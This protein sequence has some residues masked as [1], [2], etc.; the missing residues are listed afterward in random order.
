MKRK[1]PQA[2]FTLLELMVVVAII[3]ILAAVAFPAY[4]D[5][6][7]RGNR[8]DA[9]GRL[10]QLATML[11]R[12]KSQQLSYRG[13]TL[14]MINGGSAALPSTGEAKY[15]LTL[16]LTPA[17]AAVPTGWNLVAVPVGS[18]V[19]D[20]AMII[21]SQGRRC[22]DPGNDTTCDVTDA[23]KSWRSTAH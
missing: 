19:G 21:D 20:G 17:D 5:Y 22:W 9:Q 1:F 13:V 8:V 16:N 14:A 2:G 12:Y 6:V 7:V 4:T 15:N 18:Q 3:A 10:M 11:E 23:T